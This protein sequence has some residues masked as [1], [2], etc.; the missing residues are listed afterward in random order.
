MLMVVAIV[1]VVQNST[2]IEKHYTTV[3]VNEP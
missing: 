2:P 1:Y 3:Q